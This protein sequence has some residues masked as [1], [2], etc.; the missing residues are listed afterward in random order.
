M[1]LSE[2]KELLKAK[3]LTNHIS[4]N[5]EIRSVIASDLMSDVLHSGVPADLLLTGLANNQVVRTCDIAGIKA[6]LF[7]R[8]KVP[9]GE[10]IKL[11]EECTIPLLVCEHSMFEA[12]GIIYSKG[13]KP[14]E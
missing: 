3:E 5:V 2:L 9:P 8:G 11:A 4:L 14:L 12:C 7:V 1:K 13:L 6:I 10:T